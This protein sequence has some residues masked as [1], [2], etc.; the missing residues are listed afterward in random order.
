MK[1]NDDPAAYGVLLSGAATRVRTTKP[2][3]ASPFHWPACATCSVKALTAGME[4]RT[5]DAVG[6]KP[7]WRAKAS[8]VGWGCVWN[9][10]EHALRPCRC[11]PVLSAV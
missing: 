2:S 9:A 1:K 4:G 7:H 10:L 5:V 8:T 3:S 6:M 11:S